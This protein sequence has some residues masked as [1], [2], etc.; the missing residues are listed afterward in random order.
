MP[1][2]GQHNRNKQEQQGSITMHQ[3]PIWIVALIISA[4]ISVGL[5]QQ[6]A[7]TILYNGKILTVDSNF[8]IVQAVA[9]GLGE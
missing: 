8:T 2:N 9:G 7:D 4:N 6:T 3:Y 5:A 1:F